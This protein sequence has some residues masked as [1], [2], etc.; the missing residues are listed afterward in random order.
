MTYFIKRFENSI[1]EC[2]KSPALDNFQRSSITYHTL[3]ENILTHQLLWKNTGLKP[4]DKISLNAR[5][6]ANWIELFFAIVSGGYVSVELLNGFTPS[7]T[8]NLVNHSDSRILY[9]EK[10]IFSK[11]SFDKMPNLIAAIDTNTGELLAFRGDFEKYY[12]CRRIRFSEMY[13][14]GITPDDICFAER[15][16]EEVCAI[17]Y[18][19]GSTGSPKG[20]MLQIKNFSTNVEFLTRFYPYNRGENYVNLLPYGHIFGLT[21]DGIVPL[22]QGMHLVVL[23]VP[24]IPMAVKSA[25]CKY[26]PKMLIAVPMVLSKLVD[27]VIGDFVN[28]PSSK[29]KLADSERNSDFVEA[30]NII[31][32]KALGGNIELIVTGGA[33]IPRELEI[34]LIDHLDIPL[35]TAYGMSE[36]APTISCGHVGHYK[37][38][39]CGEI[40]TEYIEYRIDS[41]DPY[42]EAGELLVRGDVVFKGYYKNEEATRSVLSSDG[43]LRTGDLGIVDKDNSLFLVGRCKSMLLSTNGQNIYPEEIEEVLVTL[44]YIREG[45]VVQR[46]NILVAIVV[47]DMDKLSRENID[48]STLD[49]I[50]KENLDKLNEVMPIY[51]HIDSFELKYEPLVRTPKG[52]LRR[53]LYK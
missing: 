39:S 30:L 1:K 27:Y 53:F 20:V 10:A 18:T 21:W 14:N 7:D 33:A 29:A 34:L 2:W 43:W 42:T 26:H 8:Q 24:P 16:E 35:I 32:N 9:T 36:C 13:P 40:V 3:A 23:G 51:S 47:P 45:V 11:M 6:S 5:N 52:S 17:M 49:Y 50:M 37:P 19:S 46:D 48:A 31:L 28:I 15:D 44:P 25:L 4:G 12:S 22:C 41:G 38:K